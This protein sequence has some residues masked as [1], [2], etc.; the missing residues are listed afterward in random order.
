MFLLY[1][2]R[3][4]LCHYGP[5]ARHRH[6]PILPG[7]RGHDPDNDLGL[8]YYGNANNLTMQHTGVDPLRDLPVAMQKYPAAPRPS[9]FAS[10]CT[11]MSYEQAQASMASTKTVKARIHNMIHVTA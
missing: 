11:L 3:S 7:I 2:V 9:V 5:K 6:D 10:E 1:V 8:S 4:R